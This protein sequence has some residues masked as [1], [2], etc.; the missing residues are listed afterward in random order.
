MDWGASPA[1]RALRQ[2]R[3]VA[4]CARRTGCGADEAADILAETAATG[5]HGEPGA[6]SRRAVLGGA[7]AA[8]LA[9]TVPGRLAEPAGRPRAAGTAGW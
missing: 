8:A 1:A 7:G 4:A 6:V 9:T 2:A 5:Q 3:T